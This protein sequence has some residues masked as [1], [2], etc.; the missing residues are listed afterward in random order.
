METGPKVGS[1]HDL[2]LTELLDGD[3]HRFLVE[4]GSERG[5]GLVPELGARAAEPHDVAAAEQA[6]AHAAS[7]MGR[8]LDTRGLAELLQ[9]NREH[10]RWDGSPTAA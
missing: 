6:V 2:A 7:Q 1:G 9:R 8:T 10:P 3:V 4:V 5:A